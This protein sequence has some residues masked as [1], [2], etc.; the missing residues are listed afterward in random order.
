ML[1]L[2]SIP[3]KNHTQE[4]IFTANE[5]LEQVS[6]GLERMCMRYHPA[7]SLKGKYA[8]TKFIILMQN[9]THALGLAFPKTGRQHQIRVH[10]MIHGFPLIGDKLY[11]G[12]FPI[13][14]RFKDI[15]ATI[16][17]HQLMEILDR[18]SMPSL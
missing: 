16:F 18:H 5:R 9:Q 13:F 12:G 4:N 11:L 6:T 3:A 15:Q 1:F 17:D 8:S 2:H 10:A 14:Q 7:N